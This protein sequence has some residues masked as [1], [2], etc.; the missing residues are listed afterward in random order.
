MG[1]DHFYPNLCVLSPRTVRAV[2]GRTP[3][4]PIDWTT[5]ADCPRVPTMRG[6]R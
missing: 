3:V 5:V 1:S 2:I 4:V 6:H